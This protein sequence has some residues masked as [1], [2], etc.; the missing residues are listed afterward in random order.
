M[1]AVET[2]VTQFSQEVLLL[3]QRQLFFP[4]KGVQ[5]R[6]KENKCLK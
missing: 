1:Y 2:F 4:E 6:E 3:N 5:R